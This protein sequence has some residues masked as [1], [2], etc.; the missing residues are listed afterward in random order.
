M[1]FMNWRLFSGLA[2]LGF[3]LF[4]CSS[5]KQVKPYHEEIAVI[6]KHFSDLDKDQ[7][8]YSRT[9]TKISV[10]VNTTLEEIIDFPTLNYNIA[11]N[12]RPSSINYD[13][14]FNPSEMAYI[15]EKFATAK[16][17][18]L[19]QSWF[20]N[21]DLTRKTKHTSGEIKFT[22]LPVLSPNGNFALF[23]AEDYFGGQIYIYKKNI[24]SGEWEFF[25][26]SSIWMS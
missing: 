15:K 12:G 7:K 26:T 19:K 20:S 13:T 9:I 18:R 6:Q 17:I 23:Y 4:S 11:A 3:T 10:P 2:F 25:S 22:T 5:Q 14:I 1:L 8:L 16:P 24:S 21:I